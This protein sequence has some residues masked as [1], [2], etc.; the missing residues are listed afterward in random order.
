VATYYGADGLID[1]AA[2]DELRLGYDPST[3]AFIGP[4]LEDE[5]TNLIPY[6]NQFSSW[7]FGGGY[8]GITPQINPEGG[9]NSQFMIAPSPGSSPFT[10]YEVIGPLIG[11]RYTFSIYAKKKTANPDTGKSTFTLSVTGAAS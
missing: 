6:A 1:S 9:A 10:I 8:I 7:D 11:G 4:V 5:A 2:V 3:L